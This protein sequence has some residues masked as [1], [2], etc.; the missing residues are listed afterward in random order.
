MKSYDIFNSN[1]FAFHSCENIMDS[2]DLGICSNM[3]SMITQEYSV[4]ALE[5]FQGCPYTG[6]GFRFDVRVK[7]ERFRVDEW[8]WLPNAIR[9][10]GR[11]KEL[12][13]ESVTVMSYGMREAVMKLQIKNHGNDDLCVPIQLQ[14]GGCIRYNYLWEFDIPAPAFSAPG[15]HNIEHGISTKVSSVKCSFE[16]GV[17]CID[18][19]GLAYTLTCSENLTLFEPASFLEGRIAIPAHGVKEIYISC[20]MG[21][22]KDAVTQATCRMKDYAGAFDEAFRKLEEECKQL[23]N[24]LPRL[25]SNCPELDALYYRSF[26]TYLLCRWE[27]PELFMS[28][29][30]STGSVNGSCLCSY[31]WDYSGGLMMHPIVSPEVNKKQILAY[32]GNDLTKCYALNPV[33]G[34]AVGP[35]Y[36]INQE[37]IIRLVYYHILHTGDTEFLKEYCGGKSVLEWMIY[38]AYVC[39]DIDK[40]VA[41][42]DYGIRGNSHLELKRGKPYNGIMPD[43]NARRYMNYMLVYELTCLAGAPEE[44]LL[45]RAEG[46][47]KE[48]KSLWNDDA[49]WYDFILEGKRDT[50]YT[51]QMFKFIDSPVIDEHE[52]VGLISHLND[53]E[54]LSDFGLHSMSKIDAAYDQDDIDNGG[55]GICTLF[56]MQICAQLYA[57]GYDEVAN[58]ILKRV[59]WWGTRLP[60]LGDSCAANMVLNR[61][62]TPLQGDLSSVSC[63]QMIIFAMF[64][65]RVGFDGNISISPVKNFPA[66]QLTLSNV[67]LR[68]KEFTISIEGEEFVVSVGNTHHRAE[69]GKTITI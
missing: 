1:I 5:N 15:S 25:E 19:S 52:R 58:D 22:H 37:K 55:G 27:A 4:A 47:K 26:V 34:R 61:P 16:N 7:G 32:L 33:D 62:D 49:K 67:K 48:L 60:Y 9:R 21:T 64:G 42:Y 51:V 13:V 43:L 50:R 57:R 45:Q 30:Y 24:V 65:I 39:D 44:R 38:H 66:Q 40:P 6:T 18:N 56:T 35:W 17:L 59:L 14:F 63:A 36:M 11:Y 46:L 69:R 68:G 23:F 53:R 28:P 12:E 8:D 31:L 3:A 2:K 10:H 29:Y 54:F 20:H 41:L